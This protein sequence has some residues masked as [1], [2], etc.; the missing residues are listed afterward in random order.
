MKLCEVLTSISPYLISEERCNLILWNW[1]RRRVKPVTLSK[2]VAEYEQ[3]WKWMAEFL[4]KSESRGVKIARFRSHH[5]AT[6]CEVWMKFIRMADL[7]SERA[8]VFYKFHLNQFSWCKWVNLCF[9]SI[10]DKKIV[11]CTTYSSSYTAACH[12]NCDGHYC[13]IDVKIKL[14]A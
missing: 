13:I 5:G 12:N 6:S 1:D 3:M 2:F 14:K 7:F 11:Y 9:C 8:L 10:F 4:I